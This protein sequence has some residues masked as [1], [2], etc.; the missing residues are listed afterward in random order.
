M[1]A[2][3]DIEILLD[4]IRNTIK[5]QSDG[6]LSPDKARQSYRKLLAR[7]EKLESKYISANAGGYIKGLLH[8]H[9]A[10]N[11][12]NVTAVFMFRKG[13]PVLLAFAGDKILMNALPELIGRER[14][15]ID[16]GATARLRLGEQGGQSFSLVLKKL[17]AEREMIVVATVTSTPLFNAGDFEFLAELLKSIYI[18]NHEFFSP[19][20]LNYMN[21]LSSEISRIFNGGKEGALYADHFIL[22]NPPGAF[23]RAGIYNLIDFS[24]F[25]VKTL[26]ATYPAHVHI[27]ALSLS[28]YI[29]LYDEKTKL[30]LDIRRNRMDFIYHGNNIPYKVLQN[31]IETQQ[32]L[33]LFLESL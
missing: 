24:N 17:M 4:Q 18:K 1:A 10:A 25:I 5:M 31:E 33:Y 20:M 22:H 16:G 30:G 23:A 12:A 2:I 6:S 27:F 29:V 28:N 9:N 26:R 7:Y 19:V 15:V 21:D 14:D 32:A 13:L 11:S 8:H 3:Q